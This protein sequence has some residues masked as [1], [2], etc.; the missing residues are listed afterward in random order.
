MRLKSFL[1]GYGTTYNDLKSGTNKP[2]DFDKVLDKAK[3]PVKA[4][5]KKGSQVDVISTA[6]EKDV[7]VQHKNKKKEIVK[8]KDLTLEDLVLEYKLKK[9]TKIKNKYR[10]LTNKLARK[11]LKEHPANLFE[12]NFRKKEIAAEAL[13]MPI[14]CGFEAET[15]FYS[16][17]G[18]SSSNVDDMSLSDIEYEYGDLPDQA[19][20]DYQDW[21]YDK[22]QDEYLSDLISDKV[23]EVK[24]DEEWLND[25]I[26]SYD[27]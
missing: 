21:L 17:D 19:Y 3:E 24:E 6:G 26:D 13:D 14:K 8:S 5:D 4:T 7:V 2:A 20:Q 1:E 11:H 22:G 12:I 18:S 10:K 16:V 15:F 23:Q 25:F 9:A 27:D